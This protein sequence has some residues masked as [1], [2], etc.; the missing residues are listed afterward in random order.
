MSDLAVRLQNLYEAQ[1]IRLDERRREEKKKRHEKRK[2]QNSRSRRD[3][4]LAAIKCA[5]AVAANIESR[6]DPE[7]VV[8]FELEKFPSLSEDRHFEKLCNF[9]KEGGYHCYR[10]PDFSTCTYIATTKTLKVA[11]LREYCTG[12]WCETCP[13]NH[14]IR[15]IGVS[16]RP[17]VG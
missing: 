16:T 12:F 1:M 8:I 4:K 17:I 13:R 15:A 5:E 9:L 10:N 6:I 2:H 3:I 7:V 11:D 14:R